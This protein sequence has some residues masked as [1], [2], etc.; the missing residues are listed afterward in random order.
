M[1]TKTYSPKISE[2]Q[3]NWKIVDADGKVLGRLATQIAISLR[4]KDK[5]TFTPHLDMGDFVVVINA[6]KI[7]LTGNKM[8]KKLY[9][10]HT[11]FPGGVK[12]RTAEKMIQESP[13]EVIQQAVW[14]MLPKGAL[15]R[16]LIKKL[17]V[18]KGA[19]HPHKAQ[20]PTALGA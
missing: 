1:P 19:E 18:Y 8:Q 14:G 16:Q 3:R 12:T 2:A 10:W 7:V 5:P 13:E 15:G 11:G 9:H 20:T 4:G 6:E 17:K